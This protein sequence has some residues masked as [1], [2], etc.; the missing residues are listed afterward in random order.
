VLR[1]ADVAMFDAK[2]RGPGRMSLA[3]SERVTVVESQLRLE[4]ELRHALA[5][6]ALA[7]HYQPIVAGDGAIIAVEALLRWPH[8]RHGLLTAGPI[9]TAAEQGNLVQ[10]LDRWVLRTALTEAVNWP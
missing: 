3:D 4:G 9:L 5:T 8:P 7:L 6:G 10:D 2:S 1:H